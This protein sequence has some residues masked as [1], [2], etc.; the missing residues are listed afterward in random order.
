MMRLFKAE[1]YQLFHRKAPIIWLVVALLLGLAI[2]LIFYLSTWVDEGV[3]PIIQSLPAEPIIYLTFVPLM[4]STAIFLLIGLGNTAYHDETRNRTLINTVSSGHSR[5][6][7]YL[8]KF[9]ISL[10]LAALFLLLAIFGFSL[11]GSMMFNGDISIY[12]DII[13]VETVLSYLPI[14]L[15]YLALFQ[16]IYFFS[17][18]N[19]LTNLA[20][21][22]LIAIPLILQLLA[23]QFD[24]ITMIEPY[25]FTQLDPKSPIL[26]M[27]INFT[28]WIALLY[29]AVFLGLGI[30]I[31]KRREIK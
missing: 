11:A 6:K 19:A 10:F 21:L 16:M 20:I 18:S 14:W 30:Y 7:I 3:R 1:L 22:G 4:T 23:Y 24:F 29:F 13:V 31:F 12:F 15:M 5:T 27:A 26:F 25:I 17:T 2:P 9:L 8:V 28:P